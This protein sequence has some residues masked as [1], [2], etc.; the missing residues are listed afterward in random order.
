MVEQDTGRNYT[1]TRTH[2]QTHTYSYTDEKGEREREHKRRKG[3]YVAA[4]EGM[5]GLFIPLFSL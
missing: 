2:T 3:H 1:H 5:K 4:S